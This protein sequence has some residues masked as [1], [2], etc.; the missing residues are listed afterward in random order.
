MSTILLTGATGFLGSHLLENFITQG[1]NV[2]V[3]KRSTSVTWRVNHLLSKTKVY[4]IDKTSLK[5]IFEHEQPEIIV[6]TAC[7]YGR[8]NNGII[9]IIDSNL[10]LGLNLLEN[11]INNNVKTFINTDTLLPKNV[12][13]YS[14]SKTQL[15]EWLQKYSKQIQVIN[16]K[17][18][19]IY[20]IKDDEKKFF[21]WLIDKMINDDGEINLTSGIQKRDFIYIDDVTRAYS[22]VLN[23]RKELKDWNEFDLGTNLFTPVKEMVLIIAKEIERIY[24]KNIVSR[25]KFGVIPYREGDIMKPVLDNSKL[26]LLGWKPKVE[27]VEGVQKILKF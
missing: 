17:I 25:L 21:P 10:I 18:E 24:G 13:D 15:T 23:K 22:L 12:N 14:L 19:H 9:N 16:V 1:F 7:N 8:G 11:A 20:G 3:I 4:D 5:V 26:C 27:I 6:H 2:I